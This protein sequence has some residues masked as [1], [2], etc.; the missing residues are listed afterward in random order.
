MRYGDMRAVPRAATTASRRGSLAGRW[1]G[2]CWDGADIAQRVRL[3]V[4][5]WPV[6]T[7]RS[8]RYPLCRRPAGRSSCDAKRRT[9]LQARDRVEA[10][11]RARELG[12]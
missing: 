6:G 12:R 9:K 3:A 7:M 8:C 11:L 10:V 5:V 1:R 2:S 4:L